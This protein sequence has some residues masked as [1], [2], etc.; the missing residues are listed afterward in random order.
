MEKFK[1]DVNNRKKICEALSFLHGKNKV[2]LLTFDDIILLTEL[3]ENKLDEMGISAKNRPGAEFYFQPS[4]PTS[5]S[6]KFS[7]P[8]TSI[9]II[10]KSKNWFV[11][12]LKRIKIYPLSKKLS[13]LI[14]T[15]T[16]KNL[17]VD[18][19]CCSFIT[20]NLEKI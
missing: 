18:N 14:L 3:A 20:K 5:K 16:Q 4:G 12:E 6:Y 11:A 1:I 19:F 8:A 13:H 15:P 10:R 2:N 9:L 7:Q 17:A